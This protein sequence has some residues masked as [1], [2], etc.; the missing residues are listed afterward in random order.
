MNKYIYLYEIFIKMPF[1]RRGTIVVVRA[2][3]KNMKKGIT[4]RLIK[5]EMMYADRLEH[6]TRD[7]TRSSQLA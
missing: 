5:R 3:A 4:Q 6:I 2:P 1:A 7:E